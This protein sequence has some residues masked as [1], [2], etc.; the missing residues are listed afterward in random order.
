MR[1]YHC[2]ATLSDKNFCTSCGADV[3]LYKKIIALSNYFYNDGLAKAN[4]RDLSGA[5]TSLKKSLK[6]N[7]KH[8]MARNLLGLVY[9]E[10]GETVAALS[11]WVISKNMQPEKNIADDYIKA[12]QSNQGRLETI[13]QTIKKYNLALSY[14]HQGSEDL[15]IIQLKKVLSMNANLVQGHQLLALLFIKKEEYDRAR[16]ELDKALSIDTTNTMTLRYIKELE[17]MGVAAPVKLQTKIKSDKNRVAYQSGNDI[18]IQP[19]AYRENS[20]FWTVINI[21]IGLLVGAALVWFLVVPAQVSSIKNQYQ[22][23][24]NK[25]FESQSSQSSDLESK[26]KEIENLNTQLTQAQEQLAAYEGEQGASSM[27]ENLSK[28]VSAHIAG[29]TEEEMN[30][31]SGIDKTKLKESGAALYDTLMADTGSKMFD[32]FKNTGEQAYK[33]GD[34]AK[35]VENLQKAVNINGSDLSVL[36]YLGRSYHKN[37]QTQEAI[38]TYNKFLELY[39]NDRLASDVQEFRAKLT[40]Q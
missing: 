18:I 5:I 25:L 29:N 14:C 37:N 38:D 27:Y 6:F 23:K 26:E 8:I 19:T 34:Y 15:A 28:A 9:F 39:P 2:N 32:T 24:E 10:M 1:C 13:N 7:K 16:K 30:M 20:G 35:A 36:Y 33:S 22:K 21:L 12:I 40:N 4:V 31:L 17:E 11:E 3:T